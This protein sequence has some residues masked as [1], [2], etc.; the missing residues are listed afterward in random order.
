VIV[1]ASGTDLL[2]VLLRLSITASVAWLSWETLL[3]LDTAEDFRRIDIVLGSDLEM[4]D[5]RRN[6]RQL[7]K[8][9][10]EWK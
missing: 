5:F 7:S 1:L 9:R 10:E 2:K 4:K 8:Q 3:L 6:H